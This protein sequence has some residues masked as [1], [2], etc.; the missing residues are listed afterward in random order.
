MILLACLIVL[1]ALGLMERA[2]ARRARAAVPT[3]IHVNGTRGKST[4]TRLIAAA[5]R[6]AG[7]PAIAKVTGTAP[8]LIRPDGSERPI[9]RYAP[10]NIREQAWLLRQARRAGARVL[11]A[12]CMAVR[13]ELQWASEHEM[14]R[15]TIGVITN[16]RL[17]HTE[18]MGSTAEEVA[19]SLANGIPRGAV[20]VTGDTRFAE[21]FAA[22][23]RALGT[24][25]VIARDGAEDLAGEALWIRE[26]TAIALAVARE[27]G[28]SDDVALKGMANAAPDPGAA[29]MGIEKVAGYDV[30]WFDATAA[31]DPESLDLL[32][33][34]QPAAVIIYNHRADRPGRL[35]TFAGHSATFRRAATILLTGDRPSVTLAAGVRRLCPDAPVRFV[36]LRRLATQITNVVGDRGLPSDVIFCGNTRGWVRPFG[37]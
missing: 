19:Q 11:V 30:R 26:D 27:L 34:S 5:L 4:V 9:A 25:L 36:P 33:D 21:I 12:E 20:L 7:I 13:P 6:E 24:R 32:T 28:I 16:A 17:D 29:T 3:R 14:V 23:C 1:V 37:E 10:A 31:N 8:R 18:A 2:A 15:A 35:H 22:R